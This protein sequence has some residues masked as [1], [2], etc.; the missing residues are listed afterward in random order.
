MRLC[1]YV[2]EILDVI[3]RQLAHFDVPNEWDDV[4]P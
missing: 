2:K 3:D 4:K 1:E